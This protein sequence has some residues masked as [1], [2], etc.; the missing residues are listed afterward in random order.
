MLSISFSTFSLF[1]QRDS[2]NKSQGQGIKGK[3]DLYEEMS[4]TNSHKNR[5]T[6]KS[7]S[8]PGEFDCN[9]YPNM[10]LRA[11]YL[12]DSDQYCDPEDSEQAFDDVSLSPGHNLSLPKGTGK[13]R[14]VSYRIRF[15]IPENSNRTAKDYRNRDEERSLQKATTTGGG[16]ISGICG[17][18][19]SN[20]WVS[21]RESESNH[22]TIICNGDCGDSD[23]LG[24]NEVQ[25]TTVVDDESETK[26]DTGFCCD[27]YRPPDVWVTPIKSKDELQKWIAK[28]VWDFEYRDDE[29][30]EYEVDH[31][32]LMRGVK[33]LMRI[34]EEM[35]LIAEDWQVN[36]DERDPWEMTASNDT[37]PNL[38][39][40]TRDDSRHR[41]SVKQI[42]DVNGQCEDS[43]SVP[44]DEDIFYNQLMRVVDFPHLEE[45]E[46]SRNTEDPTES[47][48]DQSSVSDANS[49]TSFIS[50]VD[51]LDFDGSDTSSVSVSLPTNGMDNDSNQFPSEDKP[52][53][54]VS[55]LSRPNEECQESSDSLKAFNHNK[56]GYG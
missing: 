13:H 4:H 18:N 40:K 12:N 51:Y 44:L 14:K 35:G 31:S 37:A 24:K 25:C 23:I 6:I 41:F 7:L 52:E 17:Y 47:P 3:I 43:A 22:K 55:K 10:K 2:S 16:G 9:L 20:N 34:P 42:F 15:A 29:E 33:G 5:G 50:L 53:Q 49:N 54:Q 27:F 26:S 8:S 1:S 28:R 32:C 19:R 39:K 56:R 48:S 21:W 38:P 11:G 46:H 45:S 30:L 36:L